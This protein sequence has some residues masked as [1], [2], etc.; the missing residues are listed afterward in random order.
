MGNALALM[1]SFP[2]RDVFSEMDPPETLLVN[3]KGFILLA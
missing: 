3:Q 2:E 1:S